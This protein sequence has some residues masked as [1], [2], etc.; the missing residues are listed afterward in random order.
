MLTIAGSG[1]N[2]YS[3]KTLSEKIN[4]SEF[5][6]LATD[7]KFDT[8]ENKSLIPVDLK[9]EF[10]QFKF[11]CQSIKENLL[12]KKRVLYVVTGSPLFFSATKPLLK[13]LENELP[14][15]KQENINILPAE[16]SKDY[17]LRKLKIVD[18]EVNSLSLHGKTFENLDL[19]RFLTTKYTFLVCDKNSLKEIYN[20]TKYLK[21]DI[22]FYIGA[23]LGSPEE[24]IHR[25]DP[26]E[27]AQNHTALEIEKLFMPYV[28]L[29][30][31]NYEPQTSFSETEEFQ[32]KAGLI[33][34][35]DKRALT[36]QALALSPNLILWDIGA[37]SG[38]VSIDAYKIFKNFTVLFE[39]N[40]EQCAYIKENLS[41]HKVAGA[42]LIEG[43]ILDNLE[44]QPE[45][46]RI[47]VGGGGEEV[48]SKLKELYDKLKE[49]GILVA[50]IVGLEN[51]GVA[52]GVLKNLEVN[53]KVRS[54]D[55]TNY[56]KMSDKSA[57]NIGVPERPLFQVIV[58]KGENNYAK[59]K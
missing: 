4:L 47:F 13:Y 17:M 8:E 55:I 23:K 10:K 16:S 59:V 38:S 26:A 39:K 18:N 14:D 51:L 1:I 7:I 49:N 22:I 6:Y 41:K 34:K 35:L 12:Q 58:E 20:I 53:Y 2:I 3:L 29:I 54:I 42:L 31:R 30:I 43:N 44:N 33:T 52:I 46:D 56:K 50:N 57:L 15:F 27:L 45:P 21:D 40:P 32:T 28:V 25:I 19:T 11:I 24:K 37:G 9:A 36:L 5:D 48:L